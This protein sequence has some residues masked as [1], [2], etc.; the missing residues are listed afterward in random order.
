M[1]TISKN[2][3]GVVLICH[4]C[5]HIEQVAGFSESL[6]SRRTQA[7]RAMQTHARLAHG[8]VSVLR[9]LTKNYGVMGQS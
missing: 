3:E 7:A 5:A 9:P 4:G 1:Y 8:S 2:T 6:G